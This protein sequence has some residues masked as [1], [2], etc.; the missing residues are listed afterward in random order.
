MKRFMVVL[1]V[2]VL[3]VV[4]V[5]ATETLTVYTYDSFISG[6]AKQVGPI[7]EK[8]YNC[9]VNFLSFGDSG[10]LLSCLILEKSHSRAD[11]VIGLSQSQLPK[12]LQ[13]DIFLPYKPTDVAS[14]VNKSFL[15]DKEYRVIPFDYGALAIDYNIK[16]VKNP[17][18]SFKELLEP[19]FAH[20]LIVEDPRTSSTGLDFLLW[21]IGVYGDKWQDYWKDLLNSIKTVTAGWDS[22]FEMLEKG[23]APMMVSFATDEAYNYYYYKGS[24]IGVIIPS[25]GAYVMVEYAGILKRTRHLSLAHKFMDFILSKEFQS[26]IPLN[27][28][29]YPVTNVK[30]PEVYKYAPRISKDVILDPSLIQKNLSKWIEEWSMLV[31]K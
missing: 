8:M 10:S 15:V 19:R 27:Q 1:S 31:I 9:K 6:M 21:T 13:A 22:A 25:E 24:N 3:I 23:E 12:A 29:M 26:A 2:V 28:W 30:L 5:F 20:S 14:I 4:G 11:I 16:S 7:F 18:K 17:P